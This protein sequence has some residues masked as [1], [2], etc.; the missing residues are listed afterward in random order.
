MSSPNP[1]P[2][3]MMLSQFHALDAVPMGICVLQLDFTIAYWNRYLEEWTGLSRHGMVGHPLAVAWPDLWQ[4]W[5]DRLSQTSLTAPITMEGAIQ[6][7]AHPIAIAAQLA[8]V[9]PPSPSDTSYC[10]LS[11]SLAQEQRSAKTWCQHQLDP[12]LTLLQQDLTPQ[13]MLEAIATVVGKTLRADRCLITAETGGYPSR[14]QMLQAEYRREGLSSALQA[15]PLL[16]NT[17]P[18]S[19]EQDGQWILDPDHDQTRP[20]L[21]AKLPDMATGVVLP[22][23]HHNRSILWIQQCDRPR[24]WLP[25]ELAYLRLV[26]QQ[27]G[28]AIAQ[29]Q[30]IELYQ[31]QQQDLRLKATVL[32]QARSKA[33]ADNE[34]KSSFLATMSH[35][36]RTPM[37][38]VIG[39]TELLLDTDLTAQQRDFVETIR[40][41]GDA[42]I[43]II[44]DILDFSKIE[45]GKLSLNQE[46]F[47]L[48]SCVEDALDLLA[49]RASEKGLELAYLIQPNVPRV[50]IGDVVRLRQILT[51]L[52]SNAVKFTETGEVTVVVNARQL[53]LE[54][55]PTHPAH[56]HPF[57]ARYA[58]QFTVKDTG[59]GIAS[60]RL[61]YL[62]QPFNQLDPSISGNYGGTGL[63]LVIS[64]RLSE[65][66][67]GRIWVDSELGQGSTFWC[68][69]VVDAVDGPHIGLS[70]TPMLGLTDKRVLIFDPNSVSQQNLLCQTRSWGMV[71]AAVNTVEEG[72]Y[73]LSQHTFDVIILNGQLLNSQDA[74]ALQ[75]IQQQLTAQHVPMILLTQIDQAAMAQQNSTAGISYLSKPV[76]HNALCDAL[77]H[78]LDA[79]ADDLSSRSKP[80][81]PQTIEPLPLNHPELRVLVAEDNL[82][83]QK[84]ILQLLKRLGHN[85][86]I[87][88]NGV[89]VLNYLQHHACDIVLMD[90]QMPEMDGLAATR[91][92]RQQIPIEQ[93]PYVIALTANATQ[94][95]REVCL[96][97]GMD[98][99]LSK[100]IRMDALSAILQQYQTVRDRP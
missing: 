40:T 84:V 88:N 10:M 45:A 12:I 50:V 33:E 28:V 82:V 83:N 44:N 16:L 6:I 67:G 64:Q 71:A 24:S 39:M 73:L 58:L 4:V 13:P 11:L 69:V 89:E 18:P 77:L 30:K 76:K 2:I 21:W 61:R 74:V 47:K 15:L 48:R 86:D 80:S 92:I 38:A 20:T 63:G 9:P 99:Y 60:D 36:I 75:H 91:E 31:I 1:P 90:V 7:H 56:S 23:Y 46:P 52:L 96:Q 51:N 5:G 53:R 32:E 29:I 49:P 41:S 37:N 68:S 97:A 72:Q 35:E 54:S 8:P 19:L 100:P 17:L 62:F 78:S 98:N 79:S 87:A 81:M 22:I 26:S 57:T 14:P 66:M 43:V 94:G 65:L 59:I 55:T 42:L 34:A 93:Q 85:A 3:P 95:D 27:L 70:N 25:D